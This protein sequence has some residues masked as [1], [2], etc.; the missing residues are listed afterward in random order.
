MK[1]CMG[2]RTIAS[3]VKFYYVNGKKCHRL[4]PGASLKIESIFEYL[5]N[6]QSIP[7]EKMNFYRK[8]YGF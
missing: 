3:D 2:E 8:I 7:S 6:F 1:L 4:Q 5:Q